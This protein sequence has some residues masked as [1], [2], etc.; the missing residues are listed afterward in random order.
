[1]KTSH[2]LRGLLFATVLVVAQG[3][4]VFA[5]KDQQVNL[6]EGR[7]LLLGAVG[8]PATHVQI[9]QQ[10]ADHVFYFVAH[11]GT[12]KL[13]QQAVQKG[14]LQLV[15]K[16][17][18][19]TY[20]VASTQKPD[21]N[22]F[23][24]W[25]IDA[26]GALPTA[27]KLSKQLA[28]GRIPAHAKKGAGQVELL[29]SAMPG[30]DARKLLIQAGFS[31]E[32]SP[33]NQW[34]VYR[35]TCPQQDINKLAN[36]PFVAY[37]QAVPPPDKILNQSSRS[38]SHTSML[39]ASL[40]NGGRN[41]S[42]L[43]ITVGV[44]DDTDPTFH[45]DLMDRVINHTPGIVNNHGAH[46][47][48]TV[49]GAGI[50]LP[51]YAGYAPQATIISQWTS[52]IWQNAATYTQDYNMVVTNNSY[53]NIVGDCSLAGA[54][55]LYSQLL[56]QQ[57]FSFPKLLNV[58]ASGNDGE[59]TCSPFP[60]H[61][62]TVL[63]GMQS[64][65]NTITVGRTDYSQLASG[66][67]SSGPVKD[68]RLKP[69]I[70]ALG[71]AIVSDRGQFSINSAY[72]TEWGTSMSAPAITGGLVLLNERYRQLQG[73]QIP[74]GALMKALLLNGARDIGTP[75][76]DYRSGYGMMH[77][78]NSLRMLE[79]H[80]YSEKSMTQGAVHDTIITVP[81]GT[82]QL[83][84]MLYWH[85]PAANV[86]A[87]KTLVNDIDLT[88][89]A[90]G[91]GTNFPLV[92]NAN[93]GSVAAAATPGA[94]HVNNSE[95]VVINN[96]APGNYTIRA[97]G[98]DVTVASPQQY[99]MVFD[100][101][102]TGISIS[103]PFKGESWTTGSNIPISWNYN[104]TATGTFT[105]EYSLD[106]GSS[107]TV[108]NNNIAND[109]RFYQWAPPASITTTALMRITQNGS[110]ETFTTGN[111]NFIP[112]TGVAL[113]PANEQCE[114]YIKMN[115]NTVAGADNYAI[116]L[117]QGA[118]MKT[119][120]T[121]SPTATT[122]TISG[123]NKDSTYY[124]SVRVIKNGQLGRWSTPVERRPNTG[125]CA[126]AISDNDLALDSITSPVTG[127][128]FTASALTASTNIS[129]RIKN[130][131]D[132]NATAFN[133][134]YSINGA[135][136]V[137]Q[138]VSTT[139]AAGATYTHS[140]SGIDF[141]APGDYT[142][143]AVVKNTAAADANAVNDTFRTVIRHLPNPVIS[144]ATTYTDG[145]EN[146]SIVNSGTAAIGVASTNA[147]DFIS[148]DIYG[149]IRS[150]A[151]A[152]NMHSGDR[153]MT[154]DVSK[155]TPYASNPVN[156]LTG[157]FNLSNYLNTQELRFDFWY[158]HHG[159]VQGE[160]AQNRVWAR[161]NES[162]PW[163]EI[164]DL[165]ANQTPLAGNYQLVNSI[166]L[167]DLLLANGQQFSSATQVRFGQYGLYGAAD[168]T[169]YAGYTF[170]DIRLYIAA[171]DV[172]MVSIDQPYLLSCGLTANTTIRIQV[173]NSMNTALN[174]IPVSY[175]INGGI[176]VN[177]II[178]TIAANSTAIFNFAT[179]ADLSATGSYTIVATANMPGD[180]VASNNSFTVS[181]NNQ[182][183]ISSFPYLQD[184]E[185]GTGSWYSQ[186]INNSWQWGTPAS[187]TIN[188]AASGSKV[189]KTSLAGTYN[190][191]EESYLY[192]PCF[193]ISG[194]TSPTLS[195]SMAYDLE[196]CRAYNSVCDAA[197]VE[198][199]YDGA[200]WQ[201]LGAAG[202]GT[203]WYDFSAAQAWVGSNK[204]HWHVASIPLPKQAGNISFRFVMLSDEMVN[205]EGVAIDDIHIFDNSLPMFLGP[206]N[207]NPVIQNVSGTNPVDFVDGGKR[208]ATIFP[209]GNTLGNTE[210]QAW[211]N[212]TGTLRFDAHQYYADRNIT[213]KPAQRVAA[214]PVT[215]RMYF[216]DVEV[217]QLRN[218]TGCA[219]CT[220][221]KNYTKLSVV[222]YTDN[223]LTNEDGS[224]TNNAGG[225]WFTI[226]SDQIRFI[227]YSE[228]YYA[229]FSVS[230][231]SEFWIADG[232]F[233]ISLPA[234]WSRFDATKQG[235]DNAL[236]S[237]ETTNET[238]VLQYVPEVSAGNNSGFVP[239][240]IVPAKNTS[241]ASY[242]F[243]DARSNK[244]G[245]QFYR[246]KQTDRNGVV[247]YSAVKSVQFEN[248]AFRIS[249]YPNP[250]TATLQV[251]IE[252][253]TAQQYKW[254]IT[255]AAG[256]VAL[257]GNWKPNT[258][259]TM[260]LVPMQTLQSGMYNLGIF[261][262]TQW[263]YHK[264][265]KAK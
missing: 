153:A 133:V 25:G 165:G 246:I 92:L 48:G 247:S 154:L 58:F 91:G 79:Q 76:P 147:W 212:S 130:L 149:R 249:T 215:V 86:L 43:G 142:L 8:Q 185:S 187:S 170:D 64:G 59:N 208:I 251:K 89:I 3:P 178:P 157:T 232:N 116:I 125:A 252:S 115:W 259:Q 124:A 262:G 200:T 78:E 176:A 99:T 143:V 67:S 112:V 14:E 102:P 240:G 211:F 114:G 233:N 113:A 123:L 32:M 253:A 159:F 164:Y 227:P 37:V 41:L 129:I 169:H 63:S 195:F 16:M 136:F 51:Q 109:L 5:Q 235:N 90:P 134:Q 27:L 107:W 24:A 111:I 96:P 199:S 265:V 197:V 226:V 9:A 57:A 50:I 207:S 214:T 70:V 18:D 49:A 128:Q 223:V 138:A 39:A 119:I 65:K 83:K 194:L 69:E 162:S 250:V 161:G 11:T 220:P 189:W 219:T 264:I 166:E 191:L 97:S 260:L 216:T 42:G 81:A 242:Q 201:R 52:G 183:I 225:N 210:V 105:L 168:N 221:A 66:S 71:E 224:L 177:E 121:V 36:L 163:I 222:K 217:N 256:R 85:D 174:N 137:S 126:G 12:Q 257:Q 180:N 6:A 10:Q 104:G 31:P 179:T 158:K 175:T 148:A 263:R 54:Y 35:L 255:D 88:V 167:A 82:A 144:L 53:G 95:Q 1:M 17:E 19:G 243:V 132:A 254:Q 228:G 21:A 26:A 146:A 193:N 30:A 172:Q 47:T 213:V 205:R 155:A 231:F 75:G 160:D 2:F 93:P 60:Q 248:A 202:S 33:I 110:G 145:F 245:T 55:D 84:V 118:A 190:D 209:N 106:N 101:V 131:D 181:V 218:A 196:D 241:N 98:Y 206:T 239:L 45:P 4:F 230:N 198:Y 13:L 15:S 173:K 261:D 141:S 28:E 135:P 229:D 80:N 73:N 258:T 150:R 152:N 156:Y 44:G 61:Y 186:G 103:V 127:R 188:T 139:L 22:Q 94:D 72:S 7:K 237:W 238:D 46:T 203:N 244:S 108:I 171:N 40:A 100:N 184:F 122:Y 62:A 68:G 23:A 151:Y 56:D 34:N 87:A 38:M 236:L 117:K 204:T 192:S 234:N 74:N 140:F 29:I 182:P 20:L 120:A 77:L